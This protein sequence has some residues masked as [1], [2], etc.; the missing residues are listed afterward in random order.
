MLLLTDWAVLVNSPA[1]PSSWNILGGVSSLVVSSTFTT[2]SPGLLPI[3][4]PVGALTTKSGGI[5][6]LTALNSNSSKITASAV[7]AK[8]EPFKSKPGFLTN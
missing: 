3:L 6:G 1:S 7:E 8:K 2:I 4:K 5:F